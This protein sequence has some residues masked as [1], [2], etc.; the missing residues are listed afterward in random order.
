MNLEIEEDDIVGRIQG[1]G[2]WDCGKLDTEVEL[3][4]SVVDRH[5]ST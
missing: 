2:A 5:A 1:R 4:S 3:M